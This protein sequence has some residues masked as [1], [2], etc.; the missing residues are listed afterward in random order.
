MFL[1]RILDYCVLLWSS[2][3]ERFDQ[4][5]SFLLFPGK[6]VRL[7][8]K[9]TFLNKANIAIGTGCSMNHN[10]IIQGREQVVLGDYVTLSQGV[11]IL[12][13]G[14]SE[15]EIL[16]GVQVKSHYARPV[17]IKDHVWIGAG[18]I[19]LP[20]VTVGES[21]IVGAGSVVT[22]NVQSGW[23]VAG[24]PARPIRRLKNEQS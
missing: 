24:V 17:V 15:S 10:V 18:A 6:K 21:A 9:V 1:V 22:K 23:L 3:K 8:G 13:G 5:R 4:V 12:D 7:Y 2:L 11:M 16:R 14:L 19:I 20:G